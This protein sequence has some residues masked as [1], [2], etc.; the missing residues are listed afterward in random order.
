MSEETEVDIDE[1]AP[2]DLLEPAHIALKER[3]YDRCID[4]YYAQRNQHKDNAED[5]AE[6]D[7]FRSMV[8]RALLDKAVRDKT[9]P[10]EDILAIVAEL[11]ELYIDN[12]DVMMGLAKT[13]IS[14]D[15]RECIAPLDCNDRQFRAAQ[16]H[17]AQEMN[18]INSLL[19]AERDFNELP[20][21]PKERQ[22]MADLKFPGMQV[23]M[24]F[25][26]PTS[27]DVDV[28]DP[29]NSL[30]TYTILDKNYTIIAAIPHPDNTELK[31]GKVVLKKD[32]KEEE[33]EVPEYL[34][35][36]FHDY[37]PYGLLVDG[38]DFKLQINNTRAHPANKVKA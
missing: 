7:K 2:S 10:T 1:L 25:A 26:I 3:D 34:V 32:G 30:F 13:C 20:V 5:V 38:Y 19:K 37:S 29:E 16:Y 31:M 33:R 14:Y 21:G 8:F 6:I 17:V 27:F 4:L 24:V 22:V 18:N 28:I 9:D 35:R 36:H 12:A 23:R 15:V 11:N